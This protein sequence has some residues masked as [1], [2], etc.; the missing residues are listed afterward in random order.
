M[1]KILSGIF[2]VCKRLFWP[3]HLFRVIK[4]Q[5]NRKNYD[6]AT[7]DAQLKLY[8]NM[9]PG[10]FLHYGYFNNPDINP[11]DMSFQMIYQAQDD[12]AKKI[13]A[14]IK[15]YKNP[16]FDIGCGMG[17]LLK[18]LN[19]LQLHA[20]GLTPDDN[21]IQYIR[22]KYPNHVIHSKFEEFHYEEYINYFGTLITSE[23]LQYLNLD[24]A[25][26]IIQKILL[27]DG[28]WIACDYFKINNQGEKSGH[29][30]QLFESKLHEFG[31]KISFKEDITNN[32]LPT[33]GYIH[34]LATK[35][36][37]PLKDFG[38]G[39]LKV[40]APGLY[41]AVEPLLPKLDSK[42]QKN[43]NTVDPQIFSANKRYILMVIERK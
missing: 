39:K 17:G 21:Q 38:I 13:T 36:F 20:L 41:Y 37:I 12:Y 2:T 43:I 33:I 40:K 26:P 42:I 9:L 11:L 19:T 35:I 6:R 24:R 25:L 10:D 22:E 32:I 5:K 1:N 23:S 31:F 7:D 34:Y 15:D 14:L 3:P 29:A 18:H 28:V 4:L 27:K 8:H 16:V 30:W